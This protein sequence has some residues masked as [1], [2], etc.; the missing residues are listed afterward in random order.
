V[1]RHRLIIFQPQ[2]V[3]IINTPVSTFSR[4]GTAIRRSSMTISGPI[5]ATA[6]Q[7]MRSLPDSIFCGKIPDIHRS[8]GNRH[9]RLI[10]LARA[11]G[12]VQRTSV[13]SGVA[14]ALRGAAIE[15]GLL[16]RHV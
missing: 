2:P 6:Y 16:V 10:V 1:E 9:L 14:P 8:S 11:M 3:P 12:S 13:R 7:N 4:V 15:S 5:S